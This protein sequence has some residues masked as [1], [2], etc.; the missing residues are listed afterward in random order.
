[1][2]NNRIGVYLN[3]AQQSWTTYDGSSPYLDF[4]G[5]GGFTE[6]YVTDPS[7]LDQFLARVSSSGSVN[8]YLTDNL[9]SVRQIVS[10]GGSVLDALTYGTFG[11]VLTE[12]NAANGDRFKFACGEYDSITALYRFGARY[13]SPSTGRWT[14]QDPLQYIAGD[15]NLYRYVQNSP[16]IFTDPTGLDRIVH[17]SVHGWI[18]VDLWDN[19]GNKIG[20]A[21]LHFTFFEDKNKTLYQVD[22]FCTCWYPTWYDY[23]IPSTPEQ[24]RLLLEMW[25]ELENERQRDPSGPL[26]YSGGWN[27]W[28]PVIQLQRFPDVPE[29]RARGDLSGNSAPNGGGLYRW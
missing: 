1:M 29:P 5:S 12:T 6:R 4:N 17:Y 8:W 23:R 19:K 11:N 28:C 24:D 3:G 27:C 14:S 22:D 26:R 10:A 9:G 13:Y 20:Q 7:S 2:N 25:K 21:D 15:A 18:T 16:T